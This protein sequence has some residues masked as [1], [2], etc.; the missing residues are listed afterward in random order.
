MGIEELF[1]SL[2][3]FLIIFIAFKINFKTRRLIIEWAK[4]N[5][6]DIITIKYQF[7][8]WTIPWVV[9]GFHPDSFK[10]FVRGKGKTI[11]EYLITG[12]GS[13]WVSNKITV[14]KIKEFKD[15]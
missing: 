10:V 7:W 9:G 8:H 1:G 5:N 4:Y 14:N 13:W 3:F 2:L 15:T 6:F 12:G 11:N